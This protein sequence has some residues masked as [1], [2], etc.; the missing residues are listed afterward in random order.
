[1]LAAKGFERGEFLARFPAMVDDLA[2]RSLVEPTHSNHEKVV[3]IFGVPPWA[4]LSDD[5]IPVGGEK[6][7]ETTFTV[8]QKKKAGRGTLQ[9]RLVDGSRRWVLQ[10]IPLTVL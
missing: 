8:N 7:V 4:T 2:G 5:R 6:N 3:F 9:V 10:E 1:M